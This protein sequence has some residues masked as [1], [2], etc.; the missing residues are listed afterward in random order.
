MALARIH[1][2]GDL[3]TVR[4]ETLTERPQRVLDAVASLAGLDSVR[5]GEPAAANGAVH[6][7][8]PILAAAGKLAAVALRAVGARRVLQAL[9]DHPRVHRLLF[10]PARPDE[11]PRLS[12][13]AVA[14]LDRHFA[15]CLAIVE[16]GGERRADGLWFAPLHAPGQAR[17]DAWRAPP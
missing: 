16:A 11:R 15:G 4:F 9:K 7:R 6:A 17:R 14:V 12:P 2:L 5:A 3:L 13:V 10:R 1:A 8:L